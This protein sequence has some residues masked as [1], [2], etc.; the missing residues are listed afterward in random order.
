VVNESKNTDT[1]GSLGKYRWL[2]LIRGVVALLLGIAL[3]LIPITGKHRL[4]RYMGIF[5]LV[6]GASSLR[7]GLHGARATRLWLLAGIV[8]VLGGLVLIF[9]QGLANYVELDKL[10]Q[11]FA[12]V[13]I[14]TGLLH[15][16]GGYRIRQEHGRQWAWGGF[17]LGLVQIIMGV[18]ILSSPQ[19]VPPGLVYGAIIWALI[20]GI[21]FIMDAIKLRVLHYATR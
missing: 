9:H 5:W 17:F 18:L 15:I 11:L 1:S 20:G 8:G 21:G 19:E 4:V 7:W 3:L 2:S 10:L 12:L 16:L 14:L 13:A 6:T